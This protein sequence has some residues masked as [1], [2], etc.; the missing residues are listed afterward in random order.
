MNSCPVMAHG[1]L[2][3]LRNYDG[4]TTWYTVVFEDNYGTKQELLYAPDYSIASFAFT[5]CRELMDALEIG[6]DG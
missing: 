5:A 6:P 1:G 4:Y 3:L 2:E